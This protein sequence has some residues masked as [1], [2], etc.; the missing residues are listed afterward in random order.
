MT[1]DPVSIRVA[2]EHD[3]AGVLALHAGVDPHEPPAPTELERQTWARVLATADV[4]VLVAEVDGLV[5]GTASMIIM[6]NVTYDCAPTAFI[7]AVVVA[8]PYRRRGI[9]TALVQRALGD[10][11]A[12]GCD[13]VQLWSHK[14]HADDGAHQLYRNLGFEAEAEGFRLYLRSGS[15]PLP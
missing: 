2:G 4:A 10:A 15:R 6:P 11:R 8:E 1:D 3:L 12:V 14:R 9:A 5:V 13:K 7:E